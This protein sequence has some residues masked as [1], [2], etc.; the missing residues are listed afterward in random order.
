MGIKISID[1]FRTGYSS[2]GYLR[3]LSLDALKIDRYFVQDIA[4]ETTKE[5]VG[6][7]VGIAKTLHLDVIVEGIETKEQLESIKPLGAE[8]AQ[9]FYFSEAIEPEEFAKL[10]KKD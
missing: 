10:L 7:I 6:M 3:R 1:D 4:N 2:I 9:G 5:L 8:Y